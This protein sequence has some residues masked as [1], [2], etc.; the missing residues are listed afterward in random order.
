MLP[1]DLQASRLDLQLLLV[2]TIHSI[3]ACHV[4]HRGFHPPVGGEAENWLPVSTGESLQVYISKDCSL[5]VEDIPLLD[6]DAS[7]LQN[8]PQ[9]LFD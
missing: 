2:S 9:E 3:C 4:E 1:P 5:K 8:D 7:N 6:E